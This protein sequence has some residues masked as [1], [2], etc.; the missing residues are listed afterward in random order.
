MANGWLLFDKMVKK[1]TEMRFYFFPGLKETVETHLKIGN[2]VA[3]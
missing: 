3:K 1:E 2:G